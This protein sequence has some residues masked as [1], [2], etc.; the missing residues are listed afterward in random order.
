[1]DEAEY[2]KNLEHR[3]SREFAGIPECRRLG[4]WCDGFI[5]S[6][7]K[8]DSRPQ[9]IRGIA[10]ICPG[11]DQQRW[12]FTLRLHQQPRER[13]DIDWTALLPAEGM[14]RWLTVDFR[15]QRIELDPGAA[16]AEA[17][18]LE[19][20]ALVIGQ[21]LRAV[22]HG[23]FLKDS[24]A[25]NP[26]WEFDS[27]MGLR[28][29]DFLEIADRWP[30]VAQGDEVVWYAVKSALNNLLGYPHGRH[31]EW[32]QYISVSPEEVRAVLERWK[33]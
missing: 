8:L 28:H 20:D 16:V 21:C 23:P 6:E 22:A 2:W 26:W 14:T 17:I 19:N 32:H 7:Y 27:L 11:Q 1:M 29:D 9:W 4:L 15:A 25:E 18:L 13:K 10:W 31:A 12:E 33:R 30:D 3:V 24:S 5:P